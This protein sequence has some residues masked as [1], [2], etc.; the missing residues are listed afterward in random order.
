M[1]EWTDQQREWSADNPDG[2]MAPILE[3]SI[4]AAVARHPSGKATVME[5]LTLADRCDGCS[6]AAMYRLRKRDQVLDMCGH[7]WKDNA[8]SLYQSG[9]IIVVGAPDPSVMGAIRSAVLDG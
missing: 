1:S 3:R 7:H 8:Y 4:A 5:T 9:W 2:D 6:A